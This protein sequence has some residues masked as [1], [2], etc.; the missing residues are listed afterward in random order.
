MSGGSVLQKEYCP[1]FLFRNSLWGSYV[2][3]GISCKNF[4]NYESCVSLFDFQ[5]LGG[6]MR[7]NFLNDIQK[8]VVK[9][10]QKR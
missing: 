2:L 6:Y 8:W 5:C 4:V 9:T 10:A 7:E 1:H 3:V